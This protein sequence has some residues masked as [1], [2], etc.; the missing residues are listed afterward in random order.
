MATESDIESFIILQ[1]HKL[2]MKKFYQSIL[3]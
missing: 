2:K 1:L 3:I